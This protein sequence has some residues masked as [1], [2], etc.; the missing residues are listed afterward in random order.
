MYE[1]YN[2]FADCRKVLIDR[3]REPAPGRIQLLTGPRQVG[4][5]TLLL[6]LAAQFGDRTVYAAG[7]EP[8]AA[9]PGFWERRWAEAEARAKQG[10]AVL[11]LDEVHHLSDWAGRLKGEWDRARR[12]HINIHVVATGS[13]A[14]RVATGSRE[15]LA[16]R[17]ERLTL[18]HW[19]AIGLAD[20]FHLSPREAAHDL[21]RFGSYPGA[22]EFQRDFARWRAYVRDAIIGPAIGRD[23]LALGV[24][25]RPALLR[26]VF[27]IAAAL[28][29]QIVSL[30]KMLG[31]LQ[32][33]GALETV[34]HYLALLQ[35]AYLIAPIEKY[36]PQIHRRR[37]SPPKLVVLN[38]ALLSASHPNGAP[39][40]AR[41]P[42]RFGVWVENACL[43]FAINQGQQVLYWREEPL[44]TDAV[45]DGSWGKLAVE[46]KTG[47]F[48]VQ[49][50]RGLL[51]F[52]RRN[53]AFKPLVIT[54][55]GDEET[56][57]RNGIESI[58]WEDFLI[59][60]PPGK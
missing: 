43:A 50:L 45:C 21:V 47:R 49:A 10:T 54:A 37:A 3:L 18:S 1:I 53:P 56:A 15:S 28:P 40:P 14:L 48:D 27:A 6:D 51:E 24:V 42:E 57:R 13:S 58:S 34:A 23:V 55:P 17:F 30:Q 41:E 2:T 38:N 39:D 35:D 59:A 60:G 31:Q 20:A 36:S 22:V 26:Q 19:P 25:R 7:D 16:G 44:E 4:K 9:L 33:S 12:R 29:A 11:L 52:C 32:D 46:V 5:T 8:D